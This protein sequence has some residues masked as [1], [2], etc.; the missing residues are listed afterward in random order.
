MSCV[1]FGP[2]GRERRTHTGASAVVSSRGLRSTRDTKP[3]ACGEDDD[4]DGKP[5]EACW[6]LSETG[7]GTGGYDGGSSPRFP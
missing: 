1:P 6:R 7:K 5:P 4:D 2:V 3:D